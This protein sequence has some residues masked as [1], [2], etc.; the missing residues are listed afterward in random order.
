M[1]SFMF[2]TKQGV[3]GPYLAETEKTAKKMWA[4]DIDSTIDELIDYEVHTL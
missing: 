4:K 1:I 3:F 2:V